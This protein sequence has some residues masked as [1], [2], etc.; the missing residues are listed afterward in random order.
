MAAGV[1][2]VGA[3]EGAPLPPSRVR[4]PPR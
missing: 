4:R 2:V 1:E 3:A